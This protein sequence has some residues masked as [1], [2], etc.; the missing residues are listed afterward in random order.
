MKIFLHTLLIIL[1]GTFQLVKAQGILVQSDTVTQVGLVSDSLITAVDFFTN[2]S[3][4]PERFTWV[5]EEQY[6][7]QGWA[8]TVCNADNCYSTGT[9]TETLNEVDSNNQK[10]FIDVNFLVKSPG[11]GIVKITYFYP[12]DTTY[13][14]FV[15]TANATTGISKVSTVKD[16]FIYPIPAKDNLTVVFA[17]NL[18][19]NRIEVYNVLGQRI[20]TIPVAPDKSGS[21]TSL[22][23]SGLANG[24]YFLRVYTE[25]S[26]TVITKQFTK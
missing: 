18:N 22:D 13:A 14:W 12:T 8:T 4:K 2:K 24:M 19:P 6:L 7:P 10:T 16:V 15:G 1:F 3:G 21:K 17:S 9:S 23:V 25:N 20:K 26:S 11:T 5:R